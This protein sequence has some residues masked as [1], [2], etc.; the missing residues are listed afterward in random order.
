MPKKGEI[1]AESI[2][3]WQLTGGKEGGKVVGGVNLPNRYA[4][5]HNERYT[6]EVSPEEVAGHPA[7]VLKYPPKSAGK[8]RTG[9][10]RRS[11]AAADSL[12]AHERSML[13]AF[14]KLRAERQDQVKEQLE[15]EAAARAGEIEAEKAI[16]ALAKISPAAA[17]AARNAMAKAAKAA[18]AG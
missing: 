10:G 18:K 1:T 5:W 15:A 4:K 6:P 11:K 16:E 14:R 7:W 12:N 13:E 2:G 8:K 9:A 3:S 17:D